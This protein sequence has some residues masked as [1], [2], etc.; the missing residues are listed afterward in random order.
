MYQHITIHLKA[1]STR[2]K[3]IILLGFMLYFPSKIDLLNFY[4]LNNRLEKLLIPDLINRVVYEN[5]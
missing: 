2:I 3:Q 4:Y 1:D 5:F